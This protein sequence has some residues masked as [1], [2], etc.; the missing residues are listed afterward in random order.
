V[1]RARARRLL[2]VSRRRPPPFSGALSLLTAAPRKADA[3]VVTGSRRLIAAVAAMALLSVACAGTSATSTPGTSLAPASFAALAS[4]ASTAPLVTRTVIATPSPTP[5]PTFAPT[6]APTSAP[7]TEPTSTPFPQPTGYTVHIE[8]GLSP[9]WTAEAAAA[10]V[11]AGVMAYES[12]GGQVLAQPRIVSVDAVSGRNVPKDEFGCCEPANSIIWIVRAQGTF[13]NGHAGLAP[14]QRFFGTHGWFL[15]DDTGDNLGS[16]FDDIPSDLT[17]VLVGDPTTNCTWLVDRSGATWQVAWPNGWDSVFDA[18]GNVVLQRSGQ[19]AAVSGSEIGVTGSAVDQEPTCP[20]ANKV[21]A[22]AA[23]VYYS[24][25][26]L[27]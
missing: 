9:S 3:P 8:K 23:V 4:G 27:N 13:F 2:C 22:A 11:Y 15:Y 20:A 21:F 12:G 5:I 16:G 10:D 14:G 18:G 17:G 24:F 1:R 19:Q 25:G 26:P 6:F 7:T